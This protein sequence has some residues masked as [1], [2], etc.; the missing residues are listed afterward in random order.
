M[1]KSDSLYSCD[2]C[3]ERRPKTEMRS[4]FVYD[5]EGTFCHECRH[6]K[7]CSEYEFDDERIEKEE[8]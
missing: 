2:S 6:G 1:Q 5:C 3:G 4:G 7:N 8:R